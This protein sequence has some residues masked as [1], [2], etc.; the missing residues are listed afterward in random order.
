V[1]DQTIRQGSPLSAGLRRAEHFP[2][3][4]SNMAAVGEEGGK[5][6]E[7][8]L[9]IARYYE[10][11]VAQRLRLATTLLEPLLILVVG[12]LVGFIVS[13]MLLPIFELGTTLR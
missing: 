2:L 8:L 4:A 12:A 13:A 3:F 6:D 9:E 1:R 7:A 10:K 11:S 5:L